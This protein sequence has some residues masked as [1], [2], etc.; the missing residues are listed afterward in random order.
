M[1]VNKIPGDA[2]EAD[3]ITADLLAEGAITGADIG[4]GEITVAKLH[5]TLDFT[6][7]TVSGMTLASSMTDVSTTAPSTGQV[8]KW[9]GT[10]WAP[11][12]DLTATGGTGI[13]Y[14]D[15]SVNVA[16]AG[17]ANLSY[18]N[19][20]GLFTYTPPD[21]TSFSS[22]TSLSMATGATINE[23]STDST[24]AD[25]ANDA[26]PTENAVKTYVDNAVSGLLTAE[27][28]DLTAAVTWANVPDTNITEGS[29]TQHE[30]ALSITESQIS[31]LGTYITKDSSSTL[32]NKSGNISQWTN[33]SGYMTASSTNTL[34]NKSGNI[35][36]WTNDSG[37]ITGYT[38]TESD[39]TG[40]QA[41]LSIT[42]SQI[43]DLGSYL[44][45]E[46]T[47][48]LTGDSVN[49]RLQYVDEA[50]TTNN[51]DLSWAVDD[52]NLA[53]ITSGSVASDTGI[54]TFTRDDAS[55]FTVDFSA[56]FD[57]TNLARITAASWN[58][59]T[60]VLTL[61]R[62]GDST[63]V[64]VDLDGRYLTSESDTLAT[65]LARGA[66]STATAIIRF[67]YANQAAFPNAT[68]Y[69]GAIGH[70]HADGAMYFAHNGGWQRMANYSDLPTGSIF[71]ASGQSD[72][73]QTHDGTKVL[74]DLDDIAAGSA[75]KTHTSGNTPTIS[76]GTVT[77]DPSGFFLNG[78]YEDIVVRTNGAGTGTG[79]FANPTGAASIFGFRGTSGTT[80]SRHVASANMNTTSAVSLKFYL[81]AGNSSNGGENT[82]SGDDFKVYYSTNSG[83]SWTLLQTYL[84][85]SATY[86]T[87]Q[88]ITITLPSAAKTSSTMFKFENLHTA[89]AYDHWAISLAHIVDSNGDLIGAGTSGVDSSFVVNID[90]SDVINATSSA[91]TFTGSLTGNVTGN[92]TGN[93]TGNV[94]GDVTGNLTGNVTGNTSGSAA[95]FTSTTQ[96]SQFNS[97]GV[98]TAASTSAGDI[99]ATADVTA[100]YSSDAR[101]KE[102][103]VEIDNALDK[104]KSIRGVTY[105][106]KDEHIESKGGADDYFMRKHDVGVIAQEIE[107]VLPEIVAERDDGIK[108]VRYERLTALLIE[109][110]KELSA[111][112]DAQ[113]EEINILK[114]K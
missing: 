2:I 66:A 98:G 81:I 92:V 63:T 89:G 13:T 45:S 105:D 33:D 40:H 14:T 108:A 96:N 80:T 31:D 43:S 56:L 6:G 19:T 113:Q 11:G 59:S 39:V 90:G 50:G 71:T 104:V 86:K 77:A 10:Q 85:N 69:H 38:V 51:I 48:T 62:G 28:N 32:S 72:S 52:T 78:T 47:T 103:V 101:L 7:K 88:D 23:F 30:A 75:V 82:D 53:R 94:T 109:A 41:A 95:T 93:L 54:A 73:L 107:S 25:S 79:G 110:V 111:K 35:S 3:A 21:L 9:D 100:Y 17:T 24:L 74:F 70:S 55:T 76:G 5:S 60:G 18:D 42:E 44:T 68:T 61:T 34:T 29:V 49:Q 15:L 37:Y 26:I 20:S 36:Q 84:G 97:I 114:G 8:L 1:P 83:S 57:D 112:V 4:D 58:T 91:T 99:R 106:W 64:T 67:Y 27:T 46:T 87:W 16:T 65:V 12:T 22:L 102:N